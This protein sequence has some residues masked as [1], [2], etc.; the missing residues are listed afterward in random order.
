MKNKTLI[1]VIT[2][3]IVLAGTT[4]GAGYISKH[5]K[6]GFGMADNYMLRGQM[7]LRA[8][9]ELGLTPDQVKKIEQ[10]S[11]DFQESVIKRM[12]DTKVMEIKLANYLRG[13]KINKKTIEKMIKDI[14]M[15]KADMQIDRIYHFLD[16]KNILTPEQIK[17]AEELK[18]KY[19]RR[20][21]FKDRN[22]SP[23]GNDRKGERRPG[24]P[25]LR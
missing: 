24:R 9:T 17:K 21:F 16:I 22:R 7:L 6:Q 10:M 12:A 3:M 2:A 8:K 5:M 13:E 23:R 19:G 1:L 18:Y 20:A 11:F 25:G 4:F 14:S 15:K